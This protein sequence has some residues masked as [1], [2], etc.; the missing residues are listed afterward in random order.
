METYFT[1]KLWTQVYIPL[2]A[3]G[4]IIALILLYL[5]CVMVGSFFENLMNRIWNKKDGDKDG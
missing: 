1:I 3:L 5:L 4:A 2:I